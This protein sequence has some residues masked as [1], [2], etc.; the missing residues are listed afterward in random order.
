MEIQDQIR[1][2]ERIRFIT[3][4]FND[5]QGLRY[6]VPLGLI[7]LAWGSPALLRA[8]L[9]GGAL[10][11]LLGAG[12]YYRN[13][14]GEVEGQPLE[15]AAELYPVPIFSPAG[16]LS[17]L[18]GFRQVTPMA[19]LL[20]TTLAVAMALFV[21]FQAIPPNFVVHGELG[22]HPR[23]QREA[24]PYFGPP[25]IKVLEGGE[26][27]SPSM[28]K[29]VLAQAIYVLHGSLLLGVWLWRGRRRSQSHHLAL[30]ILLLGL[31]ALGTSLAF[32]AR[33]DG[34]IAQILDTLLPALVYPGLALLFCGSSMVLAGLLDHLQLV[35]G[36]GT[37]HGAGGN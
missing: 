13:T 20:L 9:L 2:L 23:I 24:A 36:L 14:F 15:P 19:R 33:P 37:A 31:A 21:Y 28:V 16:P 32:L 5:L 12:R 30:A 10:L 26:A 11:L 29:A 6:W 27:R 17:R 7:T 4:H 18:E 3:Q 25:L 35:R 8:V 1:D 34:Q 22:R